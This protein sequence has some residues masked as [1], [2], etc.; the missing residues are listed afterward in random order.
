MLSEAAFLQCFDKHCF[1]H[2]PTKFD[3]C[4]FACSLIKWFSP[5]VNKQALKLVYFPPAIQLSYGYRKIF[6]IF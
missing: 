3:N 4:T 1:G 6:F 2:S 5:V